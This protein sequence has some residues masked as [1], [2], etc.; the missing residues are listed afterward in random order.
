MSAAAVR[1]AFAQDGEKRV[2]NLAGESPIARVAAAISFDVEVVDVD[3]MSPDH[4]LHGNI[5]IEADRPP[6]IAAA[7]RFA[8]ADERPRIVKLAVTH[9][10]GSGTPAELISE[11]GIGAAQIA[12]AARDLVARGPQ[13]AVGAEAT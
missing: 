6:R 5:H 2:W 1:A 9:L 8:D 4:S 7:K 13:I 12:H 3:G 10:P 11:S